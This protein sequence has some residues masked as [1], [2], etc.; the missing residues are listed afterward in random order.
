MRTLTTMEQALASGMAD[1]IGMA[2][3]FIRQPNVVDRLLSGSCQQVTCTN[4][5][6]CAQEVAKHFR[7]L[8]CYDSNAP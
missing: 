4:C 7:P 6:R 5:N 1:F 8:R 2:R 3:P